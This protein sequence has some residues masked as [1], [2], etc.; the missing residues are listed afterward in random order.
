MTPALVLFAILG[1]EVL[2]TK[3]FAVGFGWTGCGGAA[4]RAAAAA[5]AAAL[6]RRTP[7]PAAAA[8]AAAAES[9]GAAAAAAGTTVGAV[10]GGCATV[11]D[12]A[13]VVADGAGLRGLAAK[14]LAPMAW[15]AKEGA[16][17][18]VVG[19]AAAEGATTVAAGRAV[20][21]TWAAVGAAGGDANAAMGTA[22]APRPNAE[23]GAEGA[24]VVPILTLAIPAA[25]AGVVR[26]GAARGVTGAVALVL[27]GGGGTA[28]EDVVFVVG[29]GVGGAAVFVVVVVGV[30]GVAAFNDATSFAESASCFF[31][32]SISWRDDC[33]CVSH[34][35]K[36]AFRLARSAA[37]V[38]SFASSSVTRVESSINSGVALTTSSVGST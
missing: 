29:V 8:A 17:V 7:P 9:L 31:S 14:G 35:L 2:A 6:A 34:W 1:L 19:A 21:A 26:L 27:F 37:V 12:G 3:A 36:V 15:A 38:A 33:N 16:I 30:G 28:E 23:D 32:V 24:A 10:S 25:I 4:L 22:E 18:L 11:D 13:A 20:G 5:A